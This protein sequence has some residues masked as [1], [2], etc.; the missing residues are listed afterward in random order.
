M[1]C[2]GEG[3]GSKAV[4]WWTHFGAVGRKKL[5]RRTSSL[6][7]CGRP[8]G[9]SGGGGVRGWWSIAH[10]AGR[11]YTARGSRGMVKSVGERPEQAIRGG[12]NGGAVGGKRWRRKKGCSTVGVGGGRPLSL[13]KAVDVSGVAAGKRWR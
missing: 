3:L 11:L 5:T 4:G 8:E 1:R 13:P 9:N 2:S 7:R 6:M 10:G 12:G